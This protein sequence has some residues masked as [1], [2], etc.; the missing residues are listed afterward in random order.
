MEVPLQSNLSDNTINLPPETIREM[1]DVSSRDL[2]VFAKGVLGFD[3]LQPHIHMPVCRLLELYK[4]FND[5]LA[6]P[7]EVYLEVL[8]CKHFMSMDENGKYQ[9]RVLTD[10]EIE[11]IKTRGTIRLIVLFPRG[12]LK[13]TLCSIAYPIWRS[14]RD[15][16]VRVLLAQ[17]TF[18]NAISKNSVIMKQFEDN[19]L[20]RLIWPD[21]LPT[22]RSKWSAESLCLNRSKPSTEST[23]E[24][25]GIRTQVTGRHYP[26]IIEDDTVAPDLSDLKGGNLL[27]TKDDVEQAIGWHKLVTPLLVDPASDQI[28]VVETRWFDLDLIS[29]LMRGNKQFL[30]YAR[31]VRE[32]ESGF[33]SES[34]KITYP[35]RFN[36]KVL[37]SINRELGVYLFSC[38]YLNLPL[39]SSDMVFKPQWIQ[40]FDTLPPRNMVYWTTV[41]LG[42]DP[43]ESRGEVDWNVVL[44][45]GK[46]L[47]NNRC[48]VVEYWRKKANPGEVIDEI[49]R[50]VQTWHPLEVGLEGVQYQKSLK[51]FI[52]Q[53]MLNL[54]V[55]F[56]VRVLTHARNSKATRILGLQPLFMNEMIFIQKWM[57]SLVTELLA[58]PL[59]KND[60]IIDAL[61]SQ[62]EM[63]FAS[64]LKPRPDNKEKQK[65]PLTLDH[66]IVEL[67]DRAKGK[68]KKPLI[69][70]VFDGAKRDQ[71]VLVFN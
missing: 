9:R 3:W 42:G 38:L 62:L 22:E 32:D 4:G 45:A 47:D 35:E 52:D 37:E 49:F 2:Y 61:A 60:D 31:A 43:N 67:Q 14:I 24:G 57:G 18:R 54:N 68:D 56:V 58:F 17:N 28:I 46:C 20:L 16:N 55:F 30:C 59:G 19:K 44:T 13:T 48:F 50:Q 40:Y 65:D 33:P 15:P 53:R 63:W 41:D 36:E 8:K 69:H 10:S 7:W 12:W 71:G 70:D 27:P 29:F 6:Y 64:G 23:F 21:L 26:I 1:R 25:A 11:D 39:R 34:G 51:Y 66:A 5:S